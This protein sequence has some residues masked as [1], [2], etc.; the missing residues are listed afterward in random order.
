MASYSVENCDPPSRLSDQRAGD[1]PPIV[2]LVFRLFACVGR[3]RS[4]SF[5]PLGP[6]L[7]GSRLKHMGVGKRQF[8]LSVL[9]S[10]PESISRMRWGVAKYL[11][12]PKF[13]ESLGRQFH[14]WLPA[15]PPAPNSGGYQGTPANIWNYFPFHPHFV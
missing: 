2:R 9:G 7:G 14:R 10:E 15:R 1:P 11:S 5:Y 4:E 13:A 6:A 8:L 12:L 3:G